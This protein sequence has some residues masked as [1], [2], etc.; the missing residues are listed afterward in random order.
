VLADPFLAEIAPYV[1]QLDAFQRAVFL[2]Q[3]KDL[4]MG[5]RRLA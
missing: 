4:A 5:R 2:N 3:V 1:A